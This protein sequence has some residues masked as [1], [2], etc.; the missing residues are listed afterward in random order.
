[1]ARV[2]AERGGQVELLNG[3]GMTVISLRRYP[4]SPGRQKLSAYIFSLPMSRREQL[5]PPQENGRRG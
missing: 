3:H 1:M 2:V 4:A 5:N